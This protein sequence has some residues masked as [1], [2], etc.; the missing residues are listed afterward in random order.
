[1]K[2]V[3]KFMKVSLK[4][5]EKELKNT[6]IDA[7]EVFN[8]S[9]LPQRA[10]KFSA[11]YDFYSTIDLIL[12]SGESLIIPTG[13]RCKMLEDYVLCIF[14][15]SSMGF[16]YGMALANTVGIIDCDYFNA[17]NEGHIKIKIKNNSKENLIIKK[18]ERFAQG[19]FLNYGIV[20]DDQ[21]DIERKGGI[22]STD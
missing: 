22:G 11:G 1:M 3:A 14:P 13:I 18:G 4:Q 21:V 5:L 19:I 20:E 6:D 7:N 9:I 17:D 2:K 10:T 15:R 12:E 8:A 16:K